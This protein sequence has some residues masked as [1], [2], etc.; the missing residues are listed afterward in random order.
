MAARGGYILL[1]LT[2]AA[3]PDG[4]NPFRVVVWMHAHFCDDYS[5]GPSLCRFVVMLHAGT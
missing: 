1:R 5:V 2:L 3:H 4:P